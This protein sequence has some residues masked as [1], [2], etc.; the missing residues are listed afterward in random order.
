MSA[1]PKPNSSDNSQF[2]AVPSVDLGLLAQSWFPLARTVDVRVGQTVPVDVMGQ[3]L[4]VIRNK[5]GDLG[6]IRRQCC[7]MG[8]DLSRGRVTEAGVQCPI[9]GWEFD[10]TGKRVLRDGKR[11]N[12]ASICQAS[13]CCIERH[14][15]IFA[16]FGP[17]VLFD[18][19]APTEP[20]I[21]SPVIVRDFDARYDVPTIFGFD[22]E[23]FTTV[24]N[25]ELEQ[26]EIYSTAEHHLGTRLRSKVAGNNLSDRIMRLAGLDEVDIDIAYW[27]ANLMLGH[28]RR[29]NNYAFLATLP[30]GE[31]RMRMFV[32]ILQRRPAPGVFKQLLGWL[33]FRFSQ[34]VIRAFIHQDERALSGARFDPQHAAIANNQGVQRWLDHYRSLPKISV[35]RIFHAD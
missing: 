35:A 1:T 5:S 19:P 27:G 22:S 3:S 20:V 25:R 32:A 13:L 21:Q 29:S 23:H 34:P 17:R 15:I 7:H 9:H 28:H 26:M 14:G 16:F 18:L 6:V 2:S 31:H 30:I 8:G 10:V 11:A 33:R 12:D 4:L 24:H